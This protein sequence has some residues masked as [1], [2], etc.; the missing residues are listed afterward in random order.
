[1]KLLHI[2]SKLYAVFIGILF[3]FMVFTMEQTL[4]SQVGNIM[5]LIACLRIIILGTPLDLLKNLFWKYFFYCFVSFEIV[6]E[7]I[8]SP[9]ILHHS[10]ELNTLIGFLIV[11]PI[12]IFLYKSISR[13]EN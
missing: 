3:L 10:L 6:N 1:M 8:I 12:F 7:L 13:K 11:L 5:M 4:L 9:L 2:F